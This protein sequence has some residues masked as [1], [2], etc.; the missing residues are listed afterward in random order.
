MRS[1]NRTLFCWLY[2]SFALCGEF[3]IL[4]AL[5]KLFH[6]FKRGA[7]A[8]RVVSTKAFMIHFAESLAQEQL[9]RSPIWRSP[10]LIRRFTRAKQHPCIFTEEIHRILATLNARDLLFKYGISA[11]LLPVAPDE[12]SEEANEGDDDDVVD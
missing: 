3:E 1:N 2:L 9:S 11:P 12:D 10:T 5:V 6:E 8:I 4:Y 7:I